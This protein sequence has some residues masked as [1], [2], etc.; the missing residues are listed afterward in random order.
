MT[1]RTDK[2]IAPF[3]VAGV[4]LLCLASPLF[5]NLGSQMPDYL[6]SQQLASQQ[7]QQRKELIERKKTS[8]RIKQ[9]GLSITGSTHTLTDY[10]DSPDKLP[11]IPK[12]VLN[13]YATTQAW[14]FDAS[15]QCIGRIVK[16]NF[17]SK[18]NSPSTCK[19]IPNGT[20]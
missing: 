9:T 14:V 4:G 10:L 2:Y 8:D 12:T 13:R 19:D 6:A 16:G 5:L 11:N 7:E 1:S 17:I 18:H 3:C 15:D 20:K